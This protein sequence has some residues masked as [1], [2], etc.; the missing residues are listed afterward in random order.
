M[1]KSARRAPARLPSFRIDEIDRRVAQLHGVL[2]VL[3][4]ALPPRGK[5]Q[6]FTEDL[7]NVAWLLDDLIHEVNKHAQ[8]LWKQAS[9]NQ[10]VR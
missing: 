10:E 1:S 6:V 5:A 3:M 8:A 7:R 4:S 9:A 2:G